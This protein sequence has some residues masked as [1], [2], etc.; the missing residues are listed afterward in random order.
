MHQFDKGRP[1]LRR[2]TKDHD[3]PCSANISLAGQDNAT[4]KQ[5]TSVI[6][7]NMT[8]IIRKAISTEI[9]DATSTVIFEVFPRVMDSVRDGLG[10][11]IRTY[12][13]ILPP[14]ETFETEAHKEDISY[15]GNLVTSCLDDFL[16]QLS[17]DEMFDFDFV[18]KVSTY[19]SSFT[20]SSELGTDYLTSVSS[21]D[22]APTEKDDALLFIAPSDLTGQCFSTSADAPRD[23]T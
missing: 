4:V 11:V 13:N 16:S 8:E 2:N 10:R 15:D 19:D 23:Y 20:S 5:L 7:E 6:R 17:P 3:G 1:I 12:N 22:A 14:L 18:D 21:F 9:S